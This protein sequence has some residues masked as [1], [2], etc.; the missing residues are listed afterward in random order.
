M[1]EGTAGVFRKGF[2]V[3]ALAGLL[4]AAAV[5]TGCEDA[6][7]ALGG[8][9]D[10]KKTEEQVAYDAD[11]WNTDDPADNMNQNGTLYD[12]DGFNRAGYDA[13]G[14]GKD[15]YHK[16]TDRDKDG[17][18]RDGYDTAGYDKDGYDRDGYDVNG[19][20]IYGWNQDGTANK[21]GT[22]YDD[23]GFKAD[24]T[25]KE[26]SSLFANDTENGNTV[27]YDR[28][29]Y[30]ADGWSVDPTDMTN[31]NG[32]NFKD[33]YDRNG[34][35]ANGFN[36]SGDYKN[37]NGVKYANDDT[38]GNQGYD[39]EGYN[40]AGWNKEHK[41][42]TTNDFFNNAGYDYEGYDRDG[43]NANGMDREGHERPA[44]LAGL[45]G[46]DVFASS[47]KTKDI[48]IPTQSG[49][50]Y[51]ASAES[52]TTGLSGAIFNML[53][54][55]AGGGQ[56]SNFV[57]QSA[58]LA[59]AYQQVATKYSTLSTMATAIASNEK[60]MAVQ[61]YTVLYNW[62]DYV[63]TYST[64]IDAIWNAVF[65]GKTEEKTK[66]DAY[67]A[68][69]KAGLA[70]NQSVRSEKRTELDSA[71]TTA[72]SALNTSPYNETLST[73]STGGQ[74]QAKTANTE[75]IATLKT[76]LLEQINAAM[77]VDDKVSIAADRTI[78]KNLNEILLQQ[79]GDVEELRAFL[80]DVACISGA[81]Q[82]L[83]MGSGYTLQTESSYLPAVQV[84]SKVNFQAIISAVGTQKLNDL[85]NG[86]DP[87]YL[88]L[89]QQV[90]GKDEI[91]LV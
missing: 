54:G 48:T 71:F 35:D 58:S 27:G 24:G 11:G 80:D 59:Y 46:D 82:G 78:L 87:E 42:K 2:A 49:F 85:I 69:Y 1:R 33:G 67:L 18:D 19:Y 55:L 60:T 4:A 29:G 74:A 89:K 70:S 9:D 86:F 14:Y 39:K 43:Y 45:D 47:G 7:A 12:K 37:Q 57:G 40:A 8:E 6:L 91:A 56:A 88:K 23:K 15:G 5:M 68:A 32:S 50:F 13:E 28:D 22:A 65:E 17:F 63:S 62:N 66:F 72:I 90:A 16:D 53:I 84:G 79:T 30:N 75:I 31:K 34:L 83:D 61:A 51:L 26:T 81:S 21:N 73:P 64:N 38:Y 44:K 52:T 76:K 3:F 36:I 25:Y 77:E 41:D 10:S 20:D